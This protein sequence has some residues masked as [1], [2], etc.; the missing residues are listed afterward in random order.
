MAIFRIPGG[1]GLSVRSHFACVC[2]YL[3]SL[4]LSTLRP[5]Q[6]SQIEGSMIIIF[7]MIAHPHLA[8][9]LWNCGTILCLHT[10]KK[11][12]NYMNE[13]GE[14][15]M[16]MGAQVYRQLNLHLS[17]LRGLAHTSCPNGK[18]W[19]FTVLAP[20]GV[21]QYTRTIHEVTLAHSLWRLRPLFHS[22]FL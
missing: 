2:M 17:S 4:P 3:L 19:L 13:R 10:T 8:E 7:S 16:E 12:L 5:L 21:L 20:P 11:E 9:P 1:L 6:C 15:E 22:H 18:K 14:E